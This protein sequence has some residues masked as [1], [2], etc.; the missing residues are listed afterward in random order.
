MMCNHI[1]PKEITN[2]HE[3]TSRYHKFHT[4]Q[5]ANKVLIIPL[6]KTAK[7]Y[8]HLTR[9]LRGKLFFTGERFPRFTKILSRSIVDPLCLSITQSQIFLL[10]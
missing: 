1:L 7:Y 8:Y 5:L 10:N 2:E 4:R 6:R 3:Y 9:E